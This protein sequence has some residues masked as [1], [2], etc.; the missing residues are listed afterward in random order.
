MSEAGATRPNTDRDL[1]FWR[2]FRQCG[3]RSFADRWAVVHLAVGAAL[4]VGVPGS[5]SSVASSVFLP[6]ASVLVGLGFA[7]GGN[8]MAVLQSDELHD[9]GSH[10][11]NPNAYRGWVFSYQ[12][13]LL[14]ITAVLV[15]WTLAALEVGDRLAPVIP[16]KLRGITILVGRGAAFALSS[17]AIR[18]SWQVVLGAQSM[19]IAQ[20]T[21][22]AARKAAHERRTRQAG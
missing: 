17:A 2:W 16:E 12:A 11:V 14:V 19:L 20:H 3:F 1:E 13:A 10:P 8:A 18:E 5:L 7:W 15:V 9:L 4:A 22:R 6:F 21:L